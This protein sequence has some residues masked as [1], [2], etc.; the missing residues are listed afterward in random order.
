MIDFYHV[1]ICDYSQKFSAEDRVQL[2][3]SLHKKLVELYMKNL[4]IPI[5]IEPSI[6]ENNQDAYIS[7]SNRSELF[8]KKILH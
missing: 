6:L 7:L 3:Q 1:R 4:E 8:L 5:W 2:E